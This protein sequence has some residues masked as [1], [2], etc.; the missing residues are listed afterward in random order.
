VGVRFRPA[1]RLIAINLAVLLSAA[2]VAELAFG[3]WFSARGL[4]PAGIPRNVEISFARQTLSG[5]SVFQYRRDGYGLRGEYDDPSTIDILAIGGSTTNELYVGEGDTWTAILAEKLGQGGRTVSVVN[6]GV[7]GHSTL[8]HLRSFD[9]WFPIIPGLKARYVLGYIGIND[10]HLE[11][12]AQHDDIAVHG[13]TEKIVRLIN[14]RSALYQLQRT[15]KGM[16]TARQARLLHSEVDWSRVVWR[17]IQR[18]A[19]FSAESPEEAKRVAQFGER[20]RRLIE[21]IRAFGAEP[22]IV[23]QHRGTY[24]HR[25]DRLTVASGG[26]LSNGLADYRT[27]TLFNNRAMET[28]REQKAICIDL[29]AEIEFQPGDFQDY[30][31]TTR[32]GSR[33]VAEFLYSRLKD[34]VR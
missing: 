28:C 11:F 16:L 8:G 14:D 15:L 18:P 19:D 12:Q 4:F 24:R 21:R 9:H 3:Q 2:V 34:V 33:R 6:A 31:H 20:V 10:I 17:E 22:I 29:G 27:Q 25:G 13:L 7:D 5:K 26:P 30:V 23:T 32:R 1:V